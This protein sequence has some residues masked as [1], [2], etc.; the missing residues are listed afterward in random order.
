ML[1]TLIAFVVA[2]GLLIAVHEWGHY[3][4]AVARG[5]K[6]LRFSVGF[7]RTLLRWKPRRQR[8]GQDTEFVI[9]AIPFGGYVKMLDEREAPVPEEERHLAFNTQTLT[10][11]A[12]VVA[13][14]PV[15][16]LLLAVLLYAAVN[17]IGVDEPRAVLSPPV[18]GSLAER[19]G[20]QGGDTVQRA[21]LAG[22]EL[23]PVASFEGLRWIL[24]R[25]AL[26]SQ[27]V[28]LEVARASNGRLAEVTLPLTALA[29]HDPDARLFRAIGIV[30]PLSQ[31]VIG[32]VMPG[33]AAERAGLRAGD[34]VQQVGGTPVQDGQQLRE[35]IRGSGAQGQPLAAAW[36]IERDGR[37]LQVEV[38]P[39]QAEDKGQRVGRIGALV[40]GAPDMV[41]VRRGLMDGLWAGAE[42]VWEVSALS[43]KLL[44]RMLVGELSLRNLSGPIAIADYAGKSAALGLTYYLG[45]LA[46]ISVSLGV[47]NLLPVPVLDG[48]HLMYYLWE[49]V[50]GKPVAGVW[51]ERL[52]YMGMTLLLAMMAIAMFNDVASRWG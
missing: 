43:L 28:V 51:L 13:A 25:G 9:G 14:G 3:R 2:L 48:G 19:A 49:A 12:L 37:V 22:D 5:V 38:Q 8:P 17:W 11:R 6:V 24:T 32:E 18:A 36:R 45:F 35:L 52:Q 20:L 30:S 50:T 15:A 46:F 26:D 47:L 21:A 44:G 7:G 1:L 40:G 27:D 16:N 42:R 31:P 10:T 4:M 34:V 39:D 41:T 29:T 23:A 33:G